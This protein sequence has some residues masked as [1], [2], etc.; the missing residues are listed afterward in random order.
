MSRVD[1]Y[2]YYKVIEGADDKGRRPKEKKMKVQFDS[3]NGV[4]EVTEFDSGVTIIKNLTR[5]D[6]DCA[7]NDRVYGSEIDED[8]LFWVKSEYAFRMAR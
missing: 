8:T 2:S 1:I 6:L 7:G 3:T 5:A 4:Y